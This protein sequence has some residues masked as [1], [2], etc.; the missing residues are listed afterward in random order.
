MPVITIDAPTRGINAFD[1]PEDMHPA[2]AIALDNWICRSGYLESRPV[3]TQWWGAGVNVGFDKLAVYN[4]ESSDKLL[5]FKDIGGLCRVWVHP[6]QEDWETHAAQWTTSDLEKFCTFHIN[7]KLIIIGGDFHERQYD[8]STFSTLDYTGSDPA[9]STSGAFT[10]GCNFKGR[11]IYIDEETCSFWYAE[12]GAYQGNITEF[13]LDTAAQYGGAPKHVAVWTMDTGT[14]PDDV[15]VLYFTSGEVLIYQGDDPGDPDNWEVAGSFLVA[16]PTTRHASVKVGSDLVLLSE[17]GYINLADALRV[18]Q[19]SGY[20]EYSKRIA[21]MLQ[22]MRE[23]FTSAGG[24]FNNSNSAVTTGTGLVVFNWDMS[25]ASN[26]Q[27]VLN[28]S[29]GA[30]SRWTDLDAISWVEYDGALHYADGSYVYREVRAGEETTWDSVAMNAIP[31]FTN[32]DMPDAKKQVTAVQLDT[33]FPDQSYIEVTGY[34]DFNFEGS[35][36]TPTAYT[37]LASSLTGLGEFPNVRVAMMQTTKR[38]WHNL[39]A[40]GFYVSMAVGMAMDSSAR[41]YWRSTSYRYRKAGAQ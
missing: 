28:T 25:N 35:L 37:Q 20:P 31:A 22:E 17:E 29:T 4:G 27:F 11:A 39:H 3:Y 21:P 18:D 38:G 15:L 2:D 40:Y 26:Y 5:I 9:I 36:P 12:A 34:S 16:K 8:G 24:T 13:P 7:N 30:W 6:D 41:V 14:G 19:R 23:V 33:T 32:F 1:S 10:Y